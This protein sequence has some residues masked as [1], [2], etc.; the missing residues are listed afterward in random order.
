MDILL[1]PIPHQLLPLLLVRVHVRAPRRFCLVLHF[2][3]GG[4]ATI[5]AAA[6]DRRGTLVHVFA[7]ANWQCLSPGVT[8]I[9]EPLLVSHLCLLEPPMIC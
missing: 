9:Y 5:P 1:D 3:G 7:N 6:R 8:L 2:R 4:G